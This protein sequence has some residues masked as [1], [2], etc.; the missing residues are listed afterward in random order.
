[1]N[2]RIFISI[3]NK[4]SRILRP[5]SEYNKDEPLDI[6]DTSFVYSIDPDDFFFHD[7]TPDK[8]KKIAKQ[9]Y[10]LNRFDE[11]GNTL[12]FYTQ[13]LEII[14]SLLSSSIN[15]NHRRND[16]LNALGPS[17]ID[18]AILLL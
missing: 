13:D 11:K 4:I 2:K 12:L 3:Y 16:G 7:W 9:E 6:Y 5:N 10:D 15:I 8:V 17:S 18:K 1:M 14:K